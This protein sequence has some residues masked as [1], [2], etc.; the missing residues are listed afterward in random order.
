MAQLLQPVRQPAPLVGR[1]AGTEAD[2]VE[3]ALAV[4]QSEQQRPDLPP[5]GGVAKPADHAVGGAPPLDLDHAVALARPVGQV[6]SLGH[7]AIVVAIPARQPRAGGGDPAG[8]LGQGERLRAAELGGGEGLEALPPLCQRQF[9]QR[10]PLRVHQQVEHD[11]PGPVRGDQRSDPA[12]RGMDPEQELV[13][14]QPAVDGDHDLAVEHEPGGRQRRQRVEHVREIAPERLAGL[15]LKPD[16]GPVPE[17]ET[18]EPVPL[19]L[20]LPAAASRQVGGTGGLHRRIRKLD[21]Q[22]HSPVSSR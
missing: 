19:G 16:G 5:L 20:V 7:Y 2:V 3:L 21:G 15:A 8:G 10:P 4:V 17:G 18:A 9:D 22:T 12:G 6:G 11:E 1:E 13:E 14:R